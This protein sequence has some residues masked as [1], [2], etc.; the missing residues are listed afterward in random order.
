MCLSPI[1]FVLSWSL[2][3]AMACGAVV[4]GSATAQVRE[5][6]RHGE[7]GLLV[8]FFDGE[9][10]ATAVPGLNQPAATLTVLELFEAWKPASSASGLLARL[11]FRLGR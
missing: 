2:L 7:N 1:H 6:I 3:E 10:L 9:A 11:R 8:D 5:V 4:V